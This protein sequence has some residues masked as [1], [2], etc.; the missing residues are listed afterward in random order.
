MERRAA[1]EVLTLVE[2]VDGV[3]LEARGLA[4]AIK[5]HAIGDD[6]DFFQVKILELDCVV[7][8]VGDACGE[9]KQRDIV[10]CAVLEELLASVAEK[11]L[12]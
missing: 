2:D 11:H 10:P 7:D 3:R 8:G 9:D 6:V 4:F 1:D 5:Q 12:E